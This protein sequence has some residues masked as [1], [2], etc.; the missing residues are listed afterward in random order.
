[1]AQQIV[2]KF[3]ADGAIDGEKL[4]LESGQ[5]I[6]VQDGAN[7]IELVKYQNEQV[8]VAGSQV[9]LMS[10]IIGEQQER[11]DA[12]D[13]LGLRIDATE[14]RLDVI[15]GTG[16]GSIAKAVADLVNSAPATLDTLN[17]LAQALGSDPNFATTIAT[18]IGEIENDLSAHMNALTNA[19]EASAISVSPVLGFTATDVSGALGELKTAVEA[20]AGAGTTLQ[21]ELDALEMVV[22]GVQSDVST[23]QGQVTTLQGDVS[24]LQ[25]QATDFEDRISE[26][27]QEIDGPAYEKAKFVLTSNDLAYIE[28]SHLAIEKSVMVSV[29]RL[30][31]HVT[32]DYTL[33]ES[34]GVT[35]ITWAGDFADSQSEMA[36]AAGDVVYVS[37]AYP[38]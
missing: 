14:G 37:Y 16:E 20:A 7:V 24:N 11:E 19:H 17:E 10:D 38:L 23:L 15:E 32:D 18:Q 5:A 22:D 8:L 34:N 2:K 29:G 21:G 13:A 28:L 31:A 12:D 26:L 4:L 6:R 3:I 27:E 25:G 1:M 9:A 30:M 33:S 36:L 35:R